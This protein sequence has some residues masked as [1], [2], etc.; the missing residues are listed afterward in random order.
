M[1]GLQSLDVLLQH[2]YIGFPL[3]EVLFELWFIDDSCLLLEA[4]VDLL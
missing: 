4:L 1:L 2:Q 3:V